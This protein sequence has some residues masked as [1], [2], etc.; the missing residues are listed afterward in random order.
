[1][2]TRKSRIRFW[3]IIGSVVVVLAIVG[4]IGAWVASLV[5]S[6]KDS[7][8]HAQGLVTQ[9]K[10]KATAQDVDGAIK[11]VDQLRDDTADA[12]ATTNEP[13]WLFFE[14]TPVLGSNLTAVRQLSSVLDNLVAETVDPIVAVAAGGLDSF[15]PVDGRIDVE[16]IRAVT[17]ALTT[18]DAG[19][20]KAEASLDKIETT[21]TVSQVSAAA[22]KLTDMLA[23][24]RE[25]IAE[26]QK[27][28]AVAPGLLGGDGPRTYIVLFPNNA[29]S[30]SLGGNTAAWV[31]L[32]VN[33]GK[34]EIGAQPSSADFGRD[35]GPPIVLPE[36]LEDLYGVNYF[37]VVT[38]IEL[39]PD[40]PTA[41]QIAQGFWE[42]N[43]GQVADGV[44]SFDPVAL[45]YLLWATGPLQLPTGQV[46]SSDNAVQL[47][48]SDV[49]SIY[50]SPA[51]QDAFFAG[52]AAAVFAAITTS[53]PDIPTL[54]KSLNQAIDE[55]RLMMWS[56]RPE[57]QALLAGTKMEG[58]LAPDNVDNTEI[59]VFFI[60]NSASKMSYYL[61]TGVKMTNNACVAPDAPSFNVS[62]DLHSAITAEQYVA[63]PAYVK[64]QFYKSP[65]KT[66][67]LVYVYGPV[68]ATYTDTVW[69]GNGL[70]SK[71]V[72]TGTD[73]GRPVVGVYV[74]LRPGESSNLSVNFTAAPG[75]FGLGTVRTTPMIQPTAVTVENPSCQG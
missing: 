15:K 61:Q 57:E 69:N 25:P 49:Y 54:F 66:R 40:F 68:G 43:T 39:R 7:L 31:I 12:V 42:R 36:N 21:D 44:I 3:S 62:V 56:T 23:T 1:M 51:E 70:G 24:T 63:L 73:L 18:A 32:N 47:L 11:L 38:N 74:D 59:G 30:T 19:I 64:S 13:I 48:L 27:V 33:D 34:V 65:L 20:V 4:G 29:E 71:V 53:T 58:V 55:N 46:L 41:G 50:K 6:A 52:A 67:T 10:D 35:D 72:K 5:F 9:I 28:L 45:S 8:E 37:N 75:E 60:E 16:K 14:G 22:D 17:A 2:K 26:I